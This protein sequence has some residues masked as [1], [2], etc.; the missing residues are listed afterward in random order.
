MARTWFGKNS[1]SSSLMVLPG[2]A[3]VLLSYVLQTILWPLVQPYAKPFKQ[4]RHFTKDEM[5]TETTENH[6]RT[7]SP[8][9]LTANRLHIHIHSMLQDRFMS[10][11]S[12]LLSGSSKIRGHGKTE[13]NPLLRWVNRSQ[14]TCVN[15]MVR[16]QRKQTWWRK[17]HNIN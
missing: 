2:P 11:L 16:R 9:S 14:S 13:W 4:N 1:S 17:K 10:T 15:K 6:Q 8:E 12:S 3:W 7:I 5:E